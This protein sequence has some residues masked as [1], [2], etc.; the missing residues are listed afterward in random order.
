MG[1][2]SILKQKM[3][4]TFQVVA[5]HPLWNVSFVTNLSF[6]F[7][8]FTLTDLFWYPKLPSTFW[9]LLKIVSTFFLILLICCETQKN[10]S[11]QFN[12]CIDRFFFF[13]IFTWYFLEHINLLLLNLTLLPALCGSFSGA[14]LFQR[15]DEQKFRKL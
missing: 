11:L 10:F 1:Q 7:E 14:T 4:L 13:I 2:I 8:N 12:F 3:K 5:L 9:C 6:Y 15:S